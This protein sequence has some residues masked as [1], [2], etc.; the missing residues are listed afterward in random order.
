MSDSKPDINTIARWLFGAM[1]IW[2]GVQI[3]GY[4]SDVLI[5]FVIA[6]LLAYLINPIVSIVQKK[7][8]NRTIAVL[9]T[10]SVL[11][12]ATILVL[13]LVIPLIAQEINHLSTLLAKFIQDTNFQARARDKIPTEIWSIARDYLTHEKLVSLFE[14]KNLWKIGHELGQKILPGIWQVLS[15]T[16]NI[17]LGLTGLFIILLYLIFLLIDY[18][19]FRRSWQDMLPRKH[20][21]TVVNFIQDFNRHMNRYF[22]SQALIAAIVGIIFATGFSILG[23]PMAIILGLFIGLLNMIP[24]LQLLGAIPTFLLVVL[25]CLET[26]ANFWIVLAATGGIFAIAQI[27]QDG[28]LVPKIMGKNMGL[29]PAMILLSLSIWGKLL[30]ILGLLIALPMTCL[31][32]AYYNKFIAGPMEINNA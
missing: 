19:K 26:G 7:I 14:D 31:L 11:G 25:H 2:A 30:G 28:F 17:I 13:Q 24:Y 9:A 29:N 5:P 27:V 18:E 23:L 22:R 10:L 1:L 20:R 21:N 4:L 6:F 3:L 12:A 8:K 32:L 15:G 16:A